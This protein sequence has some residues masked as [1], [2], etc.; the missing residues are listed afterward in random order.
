M[1]YYIL[2]DEV[3]R[4]VDELNETFN[5]IVGRTQNALEESNAN[6]KKVVGILTRRDAMFKYCIPRD[7]LRQIRDV[8]DVTDLFFELDG[9]WDYLNYSP[10][11]W[12][13]KQSATRSLFSDNLIPE[14][15]CLREA[16]E[17]Y[18][19]DMKFFREH[20]DVMVFCSLPISLSDKEVPDGFKEVVRRENLRTLED[21]EKCRRGIAEEYKLFE[22][23]VFIKKI[24]IGSVVLT[25]WIPSC[26][27]VDGI[28][29]EPSDEN[30]DGTSVDPIEIQDGVQV[31]EIQWSL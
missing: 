1:Y 28:E 19:A 20:T 26:A 12:L 16:M 25:F 6:P 10:L 23:L 11:E 9:Y 13:Y 8:P 21:V 17:K 27:T 2:G 3:K 15:E 30:N 14:Y 7:F 5:N 4:I 31:H 22:C 18:A 29:I 24:E